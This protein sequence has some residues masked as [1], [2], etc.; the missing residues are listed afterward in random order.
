MCCRVLSSLRCRRKWGNGTKKQTAS[1]R[2]PQPTGVPRR[3]PCKFIS[4]VRYLK[5][6]E[7]S[8]VWGRHRS[9]TLAHY[10]PWFGGGSLTERRANITAL[11]LNTQLASFQS[12]ASNSTGSSPT[13]Q[14]PSL[15]V[16]VNAKSGYI[17]CQRNCYYLS[18]MD[19]VRRP[20]LG[21]TND[22]QASSGNIEAFLRISDVAYRL[23]L[24]SVTPRRP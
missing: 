16:F 23:S 24:S 21:S 19:A 4:G 13:A 2:W 14:L 3:E 6:L 1:G 9:S 17:C 11:W 10:S 8:S 22:L 15:S 18:L 12:P 5:P 20:Q 7:V